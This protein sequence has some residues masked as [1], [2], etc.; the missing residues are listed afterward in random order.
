MSIHRAGF[1]LVTL[2]A[3]LVSPALAQPGGMKT[4]SGGMNMPMPD[5]PAHFKPT[6]RAYTTNHRFLVRLL[7][8]PDPIPFEKYYDLRFAVYDGK[9]PAEKVADAQFE[10]FAGM[11]HGLKHGFAHGMQ[12]SPK[13]EDHNGVFTVSGMFFHMM[14]PWTLRVTVQKGNEKGIAYFNLPCCGRLKAAR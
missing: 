2:L 9:H 5:K 7:S 10:I 13:V 1:T 11:R 4:S 14:G 8:V 12:S 3:V 6:L